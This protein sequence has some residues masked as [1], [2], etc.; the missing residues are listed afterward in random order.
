MGRWLAI[1]AAVVCAIGVARG[2]DPLDLVGV[3]PVPSGGRAWSIEWRRGV[4]DIDPS[5]E[6][7]VREKLQGSDFD[8]CLITL[9]ETD[10]NTRASVAR[11]V[12]LA[13]AIEMASVAVRQRWRAFR[14][15]DAILEVLDTG[16]RGERVAAVL[17]A[18]AALVLDVPHEVADALEELDH[19]RRPLPEIADE[20]RGLPPAETVNALAA[21]IREGV[22]TEKAY[23][24]LSELQDAAVYPAGFGA[25]LVGVTSESWNVRA[26]ASRAL[27]RTPEERRGEATAAL[28]AAL[29]RE[30]RPEVRQIQLSTLSKIGTRVTEEQAAPVL[31]FFGR[32]SASYNERGAA[33][34]AMLRMLG[35]RRALESFGSPEPDA[36]RAGLQAV[37]ST[38]EVMRSEDAEL[39]RAFAID[40]LAAQSTETRRFALSMTLQF[41]DEV[42]TSLA[43]AANLELRSAWLERLEHERDPQIAEGL[44]SYAALIDERGN[45]VRPR[46]PTGTPRPDP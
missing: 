18:C 25:L 20:L 44:T 16:S 33:A 12:P 43:R 27:V 42:P 3:Q 8:D 23:F 31:E 6:A 32:A 14:V 41:V 4:P 22:H 7:R 2:A 40:Q 19:G 28:L 17:A 10:R 46:L 38:P 45:F 29:A 35:L 13:S 24:A 15:G 5:R 9:V 30:G 1:I 11:L 39:L 26:S 34:S 37:L 21:A 36:A